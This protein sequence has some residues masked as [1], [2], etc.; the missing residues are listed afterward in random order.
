L[1]TPLLFWFQ[2]T[3]NIGPGFLQQQ[4]QVSEHHQNL[5][6]NVVATPLKKPYLQ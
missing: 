3:P 4:S 6:Q 5:P 1:L 2:F